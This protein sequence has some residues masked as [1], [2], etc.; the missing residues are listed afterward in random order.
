MPR[1]ILFD[2]DGTLLLTGG[3]GK[4]AFDRVFSE[5]YQIEGAWQNIH[6]DGRTDPCLIAELFERNLGRRAGSEEYL[7]VQEAYSRF[8]AQTLQEAPRFRLMPGVTQL[9]QRLQERQVGTLGL[10][11]GNFEKTAYLKLERAGLRDYFQFGGFGSDHRDRL[12]LTRLAVQ[13]GIQAL[14]RSLEP[15]E[16]FL[17]GDTIHDIRCGK[18]LGLTTIAVATGSTTKEE[19]AS[20]RPD[21]LLDSLEPLEEIYHLFL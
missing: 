5:L 6:P 2:I 15:E 14:G 13:R 19:L 21:F 20:H 12:A 9:L 11:T 16:I 3:A 10:A 1:I 8:M 4:L 17:V 18:A 7:K